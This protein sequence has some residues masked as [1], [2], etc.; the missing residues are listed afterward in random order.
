MVAQDVKEMIKLCG[1]T[2]VKAAYQQ[3][4]IVLKVVDNPR[5]NTVWRAVNPLKLN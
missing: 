1:G 5:K 3:T 4:T 2:V